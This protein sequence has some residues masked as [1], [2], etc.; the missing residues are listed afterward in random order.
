M[1]SKDTQI[2]LYYFRINLLE[3]RDSVVNAKII[4]K[5]YR[6]IRKLEESV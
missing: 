4:K 5:L 1:F 2:A 3:Q 6:K